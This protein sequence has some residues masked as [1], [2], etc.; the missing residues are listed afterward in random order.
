MLPAKAMAKISM[1]LVPD[2]NPAEVYREFFR[3]MA[4]A[5]PP[6][7]RWEVIKMAGGPASITDR[8]HPAVA[9]LDKA[10]ESPGVNVRC[11]SV[12]EGSVPV[13]AQMWTILGRRIRFDRLRAA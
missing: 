9:V 1:R 2:Q 6:T 5:C 12:K 4:A 13:V 10:L 11:S 3:Y 7:V 8:H